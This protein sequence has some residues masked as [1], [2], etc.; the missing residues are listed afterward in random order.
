MALHIKQNSTSIPFFQV[1]KAHHHL[2]QATDTVPSSPVSLQK[3]RKKKQNKFN[4][5]I[6]H[7]LKGCNTITT[8]EKTSL[9][10]FSYKM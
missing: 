9:I 5:I 6:A 2:S 10:S 3:E 1:L 4:I 7:S 8:K